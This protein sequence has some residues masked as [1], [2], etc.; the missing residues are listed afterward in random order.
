VRACVEEERVV[1][2]Y[3]SGPYFPPDEPD[4]ATRRAIIER[5]VARADAVA[6][7]LASRGHVPFTP[8]TMLR[9]WEDEHGM[10]RAVVMRISDEWLSTCDALYFIDSSAGAESERRLAARLGLPIYRSLDDVPEAGTPPSVGGSLSAEAFQGYLTEYEQCLES[11]R[12]TY[13]T[14][15]QASALFAAISAGII[16]FGNTQIPSIVGPLPI[17]F[18]YLGI[19]RPMNRYG[20]L[21]NDRLAELERRLS[22]AVP[23]L[24]MR[25]VRSFSGARKSESEIRRIA[26]FKWLWR[27]RVKEIVTLFGV[28]LILVEIYLVWDRVFS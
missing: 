19:F 4:D 7:E 11:Y 24:D 8:H 25:A 21:R 17:I 26:T 15:W 22:E 9:G 27:P 16:A 18:W 13:E 10:P 23:G 3:V 20:E 5:N 28:G 1:F 6:R 2:I 12:H 14:I